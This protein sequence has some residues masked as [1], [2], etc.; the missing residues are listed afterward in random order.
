MCAMSGKPRCAA[1]GLAVHTAGEAELFQSVRHFRSLSVTVAQA[2]PDI[3]VRSQ[4][5][6]GKR[7]N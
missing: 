1:A 6:A 3:V 7:A 5:R 4:S 2:R